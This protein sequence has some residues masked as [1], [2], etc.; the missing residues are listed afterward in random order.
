[1][2]GLSPSPEANL[3]ALH[4]YTESFRLWNFSQGAVMAVTLSMV[5]MLFLALRMYVTK[6]ERSL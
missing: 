4:I 2:M 5:L 3:L 1:M 6:K